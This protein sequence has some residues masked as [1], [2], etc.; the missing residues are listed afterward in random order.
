MFVKLGSHWINSDT[1]DS[2]LEGEDQG[3]FMLQVFFNRD[4]KM[5]WTCMNFLNLFD[6]DAKDALKWLKEQRAII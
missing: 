1:I 4:V 3:E 5:G 2:F 6:D